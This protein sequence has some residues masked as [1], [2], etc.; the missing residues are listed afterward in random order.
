MKKF[1]LILVSLLFV[2]A[3]PFTVAAGE[4]FVIDHYQVDIDVLENNVYKITEQIDVDFSA[5]RH[6]IYREIPLRFDDI[7]VVISSI[8]VP[9]Y[10]SSINRDRDFAT[11]QIGSADVYVNGKQSY[12]ISYTYDVGADSLSHMDE[13]N[14]NLIGTHWDTTIAAVDFSIRLPKAFAA[15]DVNCTSGRQGSTDNTRVEWQVSGDTISGRMLEPLQNHQG[16]TVA[17]PLPEGYWVGAEKHRDPGWLLFTILGYPLYLLVIVLAAVT[18]YRKGRDNKLFPTV[19]F[20]PPEGM[21]PAEVGYVI[22]GRVDGKDVTSLILYWAEKGF[23]EIEEETSGMLIFKSKVLN[24]TRLKDLD[25]SAKDY[26][27]TLFQKLFSYGDGTRVSTSDLGNKFYTAVSQARSEI[28]KSFNNDPKRRLN[29]KGVARFKTQISLLAALPVISVLFQGF[30]VQMG[31]VWPA[32]LFAVPF[33]LFLLIPSF[34]FGAALSGARMGCAIMFPMLFGGFSAVFFA[35]LCVVEGG[36]PIYQY[37][38]AILTAIIAS[39]FISLMSRRTKYGD[40]ILEKT[41][42][43]REFIEVA[44]KAK[45][46]ALFESNPSYFYSILPY[47]MVLGLSDK[48]SAHFDGMAVAPPNWYRGSEYKTFSAASFTHSLNDSFSTMTSSMTS[49]PASSGSSGSSGSS[50][51]GG[52]SGGGSGGGGGGSW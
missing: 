6:G 11:I 37:G 48:W 49:A 42:G 14:H 31:S 23:L 39:T 29:V 7:P 21:T 4:Y 18:W 41:L 50:S 27:K 45:L 38:A 43:F 8:S 33:S 2:A 36:V 52:S 28:E 32:L 1:S 35:L 19:E 47:A 12:R 46:E 15:E 16:L 51:S 5:A 44:E 9:G 3:V 30:M 26:E 10:R 22:D 17:L 34:M 24:I 13:F 20:N 25:K 40:R